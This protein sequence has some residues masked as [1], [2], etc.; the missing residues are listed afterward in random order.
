M[1][2]LHKIY[3]YMSDAAKRKAKQKWA[4]ERT[5]LDNARR[6]R[7]VFFIDPDDEEFKDIM[8]NERRKLEIPMPGSIPCKFQRD[9]YRETCRTVEEHKT[10]YA[11]I[12]EADE[13]LRIRMEGAPH[14]YHG[15]HIA[16]KSVNTLNHY[17]L[18][19]KFLPMPESLKIRDAKA[20][21]AKMGK[22]GK[23]IGMAADESQKQER[24]DR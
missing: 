10:K 1:D 18:V 9:K 3:Y 11:F 17:N 2:R 14:R 16:A 8:K 21:L 19:H 22:I 7:G 4:I 23:D 6:L 5:K 12:V 15:D 24:S 13:S 20:E